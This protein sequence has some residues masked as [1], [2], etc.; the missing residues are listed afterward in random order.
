MML[1]RYTDLSWYTIIQ[2]NISTIDNTLM[3]KRLLTVDWK[4]INGAAIKKRILHLRENADGF[5][6]CPIPTCLHIGFKSSRGLRKHINNTHAW[7]Y[8]FE[9]L[10]VINRDEVVKETR[11]R[12]KTSTHKMPAFS[13]ET[14]AG[15]EFLDWLQTPCGGGKCEKEAIQVAR[16]GMKFLM[17]S[18]GECQGNQYAND[19]YIDCCVGSP[20]IVMNF[21]KMITLSSKY[22]NFYT[23]V[24]N[25]FYFF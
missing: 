22:W 9:E 10:P 20:S 21:L 3:P 13:L 19:E 2:H 8:Y 12:V 4:S 11:R 24:T 16:R 25:F 7:F 15:K 1:H 14:G 17:A 6:L 23:I 18:M 5:F